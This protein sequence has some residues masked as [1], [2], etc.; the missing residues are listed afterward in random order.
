[1]IDWTQDENTS[2][3][4][5]FEGTVLEALQMEFESWAYMLAVEN[6]TLW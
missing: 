1:M 6:L 3:L 4:Q 2:Q 5:S